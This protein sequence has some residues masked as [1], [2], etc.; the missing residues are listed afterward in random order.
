MLVAMT[1][2]TPGHLPVEKLNAGN[3]G[4]GNGFEVGGDTLFRGIAS[5][6]EK[7]R[8]GTKNGRGLAK[9]CCVGVEVE[10][11]GELGGIGEE[12]WCGG[13]LCRNDNMLGGR[14]CVLSNGGGERCALVEDDK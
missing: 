4:G 2:E 7:Q 3:S 8:F 14:R 10:G 12:W 6:E 9:C 11:P 13:R 1:P 5:D